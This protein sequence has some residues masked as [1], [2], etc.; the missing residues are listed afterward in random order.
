MAHLKA[1]D[2]SLYGLELIMAV[3][4]KVKF[5]TEGVSQS[6][7]Q[8]KVDQVVELYPTLVAS[9]VEVEVPKLEVKE[10]K[11]VVEKVELKEEPKVEEVKEEEKVEEV[12]AEEPKVE[13]KEE[14]DDEDDHKKEVKGRKKSTK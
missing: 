3:V 13:E 5:N 12:K 7:E 6:F 11:P 1:I 10:V 8:D 9:H 4:D 2:T 14:E